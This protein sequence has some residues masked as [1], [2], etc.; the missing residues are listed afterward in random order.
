MK[1]M[2]LFIVILDAM[3]VEIVMEIQEIKCQHKWLYGCV[4][5]MVA[6][7]R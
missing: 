2:A 6:S 4:S 7:M 1:E 5:T 3:V